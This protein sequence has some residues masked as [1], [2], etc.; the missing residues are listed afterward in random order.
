QPFP[1]GPHGERRFAAPIR[2]EIPKALDR[3]PPI[4]M[5]LSPADGRIDLLPEEIDLHTLSARRMVLD[6][7]ALEAVVAGRVSRVLAP[8]P[9]GS[10]L[11]LVFRTIRD[12]GARTQTL[13]GE[14]E[15]EPQKSVAQ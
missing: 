6:R 5:A 13:H 3:V 9:D 2:R 8:L 15:G 1:R 12:R 14:V 10:P 11:T 7:P 4:P